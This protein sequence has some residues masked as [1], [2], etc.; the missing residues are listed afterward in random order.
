MNAEN[1]NMHEGTFAF[2][3]PFWK[4]R[5]FREN[6]NKCEGANFILGREDKVMHLACSDIMIMCAHKE[7]T[8]PKDIF[9]S[10]LKEWK[11]SDI[12]DN[13]KTKINYYNSLF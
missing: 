13:I 3:K 8:I 1:K 5:N 11:L 9:Y 4:K 10:Y 6:D 12:S 7:N 2:R